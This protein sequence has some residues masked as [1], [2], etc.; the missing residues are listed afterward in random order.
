MSTRSSIAYDDEKEEFH[1]YREMLDG[2]IH[3]ECKADE[4]VLDSH[5]NLTLNLS[6][7]A[8]ELIKALAKQQTKMAEGQK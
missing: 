1:L 8:P 6:K 7:L 4:A 5:G 3:I 2:A